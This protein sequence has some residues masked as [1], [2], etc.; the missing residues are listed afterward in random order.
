MSIRK[1]PSDLLSFC[2]TDDAVGHRRRPQTEVLDRIDPHSLTKRAVED[3]RVC[4]SGTVVVPGLCVTPCIWEVGV[5][6]RLILWVGLWKGRLDW[7]TR[8]SARTTYLIGGNGGSDEA[9]G[10]SEPSNGL[11][12]HD[13]DG[14]CKMI[15]ERVAAPY[16]PP[17]VT[18]ATVPSTIK[19][20]LPAVVLD[21]TRPGMD[22]ERD[23]EGPPTLVC[24]PDL[25]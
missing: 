24:V 20:F 21:E 4:R 3:G 2:V 18:I 6:K 5:G 22:P 8:H 13:D 9:R 23:W 10:C 25:K 15:L 11:E 12:E 14:V 17:T 19:R 7:A 16:S 1:T